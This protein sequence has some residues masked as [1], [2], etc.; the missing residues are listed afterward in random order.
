MSSSPQKNRKT[1]TAAKLECPSCGMLSM[2]V[3][4]GSFKTEDG[5]HIHNISRWVCDNCQEEVLDLHAMK[6]IRRQRASKSVLA[7]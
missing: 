2:K 1:K 6:E 4:K 5:I 3:K 7:E